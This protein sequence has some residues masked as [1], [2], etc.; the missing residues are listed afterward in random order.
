MSFH[1][2]KTSQCQNHALS[3]LRR[4]SE[5]RRDCHFFTVEDMQIAAMCYWN[6]QTLRECLNRFV[7]KGLVIKLYVGRRVLF[8]LRNPILTK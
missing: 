5:E 2:I 7:T 6:D 1:T 3:I 4:A 8:C